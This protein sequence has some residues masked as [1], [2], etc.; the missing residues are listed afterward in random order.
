MKNGLIKAEPLHVHIYRQLW[1]KIRAIRHVISENHPPGSNIYIFKKYFKISSQKPPR[2]FF[3]VNLIKEGAARLKM[4]CMHI[5]EM[6]F[7]RLV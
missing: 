2:G 7:L 6:K 1:L 4:D 5:L 3:I